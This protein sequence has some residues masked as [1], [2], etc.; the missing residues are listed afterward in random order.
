MGWNNIC[1]YQGKW[2]EACLASGWEEMYPHEEFTFSKL[3]SWV[4]V[5]L[6]LT[7]EFHCAIQY[8]ASLTD[9]Q[10]AYQEVS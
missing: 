3:V 4:K 7:N 5:P 10:A 1:C 8:P 6:Q 9:E 2:L